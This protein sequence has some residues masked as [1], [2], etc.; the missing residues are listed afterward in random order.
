VEAER[1]ACGGEVRL[2]ELLSAFELHVNSPFS[3]DHPSTSVPR[4]EEDKL[5]V[6][7]PG[8]PSSRSILKLLLAAAGILLKFGFPQ[9]A[10][11]KSSDASAHCVMLKANSSV[12]SSCTATS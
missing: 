12:P 10:S 5:K 6:S 7:H 4:S 8:S 11:G 2:L 3:L 9:L 1:R